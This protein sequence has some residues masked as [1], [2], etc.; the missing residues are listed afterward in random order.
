MQELKEY[1]SKRV[2]RALTRLSKSLS[3]DDVR[4]RFTSWTLDDAP[5]AEMS[6]EAAE[7]QIMKTLSWRLRNIIEQWEED[8]KVF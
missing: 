3:M 6:W 7:N 4:M 2:Y 5:K 8:N 1:L